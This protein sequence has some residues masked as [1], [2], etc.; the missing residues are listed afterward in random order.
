MGLV[1]RTERIRPA[2][3]GTRPDNLA[4]AA[5]A[6][7]TW[8][9]FCRV[10]DNFGDAGVCWRLAA[11]LAARGHGVRLWIDDP[12]PLSFM[13]P[14]GCAGVQVLPW[15]Q[16]ESAAVPWSPGEVVIEAFGC[17]L[18]ERVIAALGAAAAPPVWINLEYL[19][20]E[21]FVERSHALPSPQRNGL[22]KW[23]YFPGFTTRTGGLLREP[24]LLA[25]QRAFDRTAWLASH[26]LHRRPGEQVVLVFCYDS[27]DLGVLA[28]GLADTPTLWLLTPAASRSAWDALAGRAPATA[29]VF[30]LPWL[31][32]RE[33]D[34]ALWSTDLNVVRGED[35]LVR[36]IWAGVP[37]VW[38]LYPQ[39]APVL[40]A[41]LDA[42]LG[43]WA[44]DP[45]D[46]A[47]RA[48][49]RQLTAGVNR[50]LLPGAQT[51]APGPPRL[52][53]M[54]LWRAR[55]RA[56]RD[57]LVSQPDLSTQLLQFVASKAS[58]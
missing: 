38:N 35:S 46:A 32:Q 28:A 45:A 50:L 4:M 10:V 58:A 44:P 26:G 15:A 7:W 52:P 48:D 36:A 9:L 12:Q 6:R 39:E 49:L 34:R 27:A 30:E 54:P 3:P 55:A 31:S 43:Q 53:P 56:F 8:D 25:E 17:E 24:G 11:D 1:G 37:W 13:A 57:H 5:D 42:L 29:R 19:S 23:F 2:G 20:A 41:K 33:F 18:P 51:A 47:L 40:E 22:V 16:A 21:P 14:G